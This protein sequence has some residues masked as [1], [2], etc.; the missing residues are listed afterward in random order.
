ME[1]GYL[2]EIIKI[3]FTYVCNTMV[4]E[5]SKRLL[6]QPDLLMEK[7]LLGKITFLDQ[8]FM[9]L[10]RGQMCQG[11]SSNK[12]QVFRG[13]EPALIDSICILS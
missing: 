3:V 1:N 5:S 4:N 8:P 11:R 2:G 12:R 13:F 7:N 9:K 6:N 10:R